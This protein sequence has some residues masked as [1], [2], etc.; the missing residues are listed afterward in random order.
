MDD[1]TTA[2]N[3]PA[4]GAPAAPAPATG[5]AKKEKTPAQLLKEERIV[6]VKAALKSFP[7]L[8]EGF[9]TPRGVYFDEAA[10]MESVDGDEEQVTKVQPAKK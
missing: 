4:A 6:E 5:A 10:A 7:V 3:T 8:K 1:N 2:N 9:V